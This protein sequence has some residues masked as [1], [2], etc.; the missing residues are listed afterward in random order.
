MITDKCC[1]CQD[2]FTSDKEF[3]SL[4]PCGHVM[5]T[6]CFHL[7]DQ[8]NDEMGHYD[9]EA[10][11]SDAS[12]PLHCPLCQKDID[13]YQKLYL[14]ISECPQCEETKLSTN[15]NNNQTGNLDSDD[16]SII[17]IDKMKFE[18]VDNNDEMMVSWPVHVKNKKSKGKRN[19][20][21]DFESKYLQAEKKICEM[22]KKLHE[23]RTN[24]RMLEWRENDMKRRLQRAFDTQESENER[25]EAEN[26]SLK[27]ALERCKIEMKQTFDRIKNLFSPMH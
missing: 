11:N 27:V 1:I 2:G 8:H 9:N 7:M 6:A 15:Q 10:E 14:N 3:G 13:Y 23:E 12:D 22:K 4:S 21:N 17:E 24:F 18:T 5:H 25:L 19:Y 16:S 20:D 26:K